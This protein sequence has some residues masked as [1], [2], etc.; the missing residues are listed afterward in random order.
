MK[1]WERD[2]ENWWN[3]LDKVKTFEGANYKSTCKF[4]WMNAIKSRPIDAPLKSVSSRLSE[5]Q[6]IDEEENEEWHLSHDEDNESR[7]IEELF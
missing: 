2:F 3:S 6:L 4:T 7:R 1:Q 5:K